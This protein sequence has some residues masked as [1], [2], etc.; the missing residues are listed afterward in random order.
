MNRIRTVLIYTRNQRLRKNLAVAVADILEGRV[1]SVTSSSELRSGVET[2][3][4]VGMIVD[5][6]T[7]DP[8]AADVMRK[9]R[10]VRALNILPTVFIHDESEGTRDL[11][12]ENA[13]NWLSRGLGAIEVAERLAKEI[14]EFSGIEPSSFG[15]L[16]QRASTDRVRRVRESARSRFSE[17]LA[18][19]EAELPKVEEN[20]VERVARELEDCSKLLSVLGLEEA[21][22]AALAP[23]N[24]QSNP[25]L[26]DLESAVEELKRVTGSLRLADEVVRAAVVSATPDLARPLM[27]AWGERADVRVFSDPD[28]FG[29]ATRWFVPEVV[30]IFDEDDRLTSR[31]LLGLRYHGTFVQPMVAVILTEGSTPGAS[32]ADF[33][34]HAIFNG[35]TDLDEVA[36]RIHSEVQ[37]RRAYRP[38]VLVYDNAGPE[39]AEISE[40]LEQMGLQVTVTQK[41]CD[42]LGLAEYD[43]AD[44]LV[45]RDSYPDRTGAD[46]CRAL[47]EKNPFLLTSIF[48]A[49]L[50]GGNVPASTYWEAGADEFMGDVEDRKE[51]KFRS[52][53]LIERTQARRYLAETDAVTGLRHACAL[54][55]S[56]F[57]LAQQTPSTGISILSVTVD[58]FGRVRAN[59][60]VETSRTVL[61]TIADALDGVLPDTRIFRGWGAKYYVVNDGRFEEDEMSR[62][63][64]GIED[65]RRI[66]FRNKE[67]HGFYVT[68]H[69]AHLSIAPG[70]IEVSKMLNA[71]SR[72]SDRA[73]VSGTMLS[74]HLEAEAI[75]DVPLKVRTESNRQSRW[76]PV[77]LTHSDD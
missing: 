30:I 1:V 58:D 28:Q 73:A 41:S 64:R 32:A 33:D 31:T 63:K 24:L 43:W 16:S 40:M 72:L 25:T 54:A 47:R 12:A 62:L 13:S 70:V 37:Q 65:M 14:P 76:T 2:Y 69:A 18:G 20:G 74:A 50:D 22:S 75:S 71:L 36:I 77:V 51:F 60:G 3:Q 35:T 61:R 6:H 67:G 10:A 34:A 56:L 38:R 52:R 11:R 39:S 48:V 23:L 19:L 44:M 66:T 17:I 8:E 29:L 4:P 46:M 59:Y 9:M 53:K 45:L 57:E 55:K 15:E 5:F 26:A 68:M 49:S 7:G 42:V 21:S 27:E